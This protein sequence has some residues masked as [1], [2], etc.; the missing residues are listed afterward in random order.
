MSFRIDRGAEKSRQKC[1]RRYTH[2]HIYIYCKKKRVMR[3]IYGRKKEEELR[4]GA[5]NKDTRIEF[6]SSIIND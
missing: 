3:I 1:K 2:T 6:N 5:K 4:S